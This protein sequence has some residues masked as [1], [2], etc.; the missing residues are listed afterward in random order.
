MIL[1]FMVVTAVLVVSFGRLGDMFGRVK[2]FNLGFTIFTVFSSAPDDHLDAGHRAAIWL[3]VMRI[4]QGV[5]AAFLVANSAAILTDAFPEHQRGMALGINQI[6]GISGL[7]IGLVLGGLLAP[8][9]LAADLPRLGAR[10]HRRHPLV[11]LQPARAALRPDRKI[12]WWGNVTF[13]LG[14]VAVMVG[15]TYGIQP[16]GGHTMGWTSPLVLACFFVGIALLVVFVLVEQ[17][18]D[19]PMFHLSPLQDPAFTAG[20]SPASSPRL[21]RGG[22][23]F[24]L[25]IWLQGIWLPLHG[26]S[27]ESTP[28]W[29]AISCCR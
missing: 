18:S 5:G 8:I 21:A 15:I 16:Y 10:R 3:I 22:L 17:R 28:L 25:I 24:M 7:F 11:Y 1:G 9:E 12:D 19:D 20:T 13:A 26:Y 29:A 27:F 4:F 2:M 14:L 6:A 23:M